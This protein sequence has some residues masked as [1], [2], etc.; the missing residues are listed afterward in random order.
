[1]VFLKSNRSEGKAS[2]YLAHGRRVDGH[3]RTEL[4]K[5]LGH[6][7]P[8]QVTRI[9]RLLKALG[10]DA[11]NLDLGPDDLI[12]KKNP[13]ES[14]RTISRVNRG[15]RLSDDSHSPI[16]AIPVDGA[17]RRER[18]GNTV[19]AV[20]IFCGAGGLT[21]GLLEAGIV[22]RAG[23]DNDEAGRHPYT[24]NNG[25]PFLNADVRNLRA[26]DVAEIL[27]PEPNLLAGCAPCQPYSIMTNK[28]KTADAREHLLNDFLKIVEG[29]RPTYVTVE[30]VPGLT[31]SG[32]FRYFVS[33]LKKG[34]YH[35]DWKVV[36][37]SRYGVPQH[38]RRL[39]LLASKAGP[40]NVPPPRRGRPPTVRGAIGGL[41]K[42]RAGKC[43]DLDRLHRAAGLTRANLDRIRATPMGGGW[44]DW[45]DELKLKC[46]RS[47][48]AEKNYKH[49]YGRMNWGSPS[50]PITTKFFNL[51]SGRHG[52]PDQNRAI[53]L[54]EGALLQ[55][56]PRDYSFTPIGKDPELI[57]EGRLIGN[58]VPVKLAAA[59]GGVVVRDAA[60]HFVR[61]SEG[62]R[63]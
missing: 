1:V 28:V 15:P 26:K 27:G 12:R 11:S 60:L 34:G 33:R 23:Y 24:A 4:L 61:T 43:D 36:D 3:V 50:P 6:L 10:R 52:H 2:W 39:I 31:R 41:P 56:F 16:R 57:V 21:R 8:H 62:N 7:A 14:K 45:P 32:V 19:T 49:S 51:G 25:V 59:I 5:P 48:D 18:K 42:L 37:A 53:S 29:V 63:L 40:I 35:V 22:V 20:D 46:Q 44:Q 55:S 30:N 17:H 47:S 58:A 13:E 9:R 54:R 38:R